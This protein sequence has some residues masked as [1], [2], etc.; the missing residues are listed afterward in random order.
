MSLDYCYCWVLTAD[1]L[2]ILFRWTSYLLFQNLSCYFFLFLSLVAS[3]I[4][5]FS[6]FLCSCFK[7]SM[8]RK[9]YASVTCN[10]LVYFRYSTLKSSI[11]IFSPEKKQKMS[12]YCKLN[13]FQN[14]CHV[15]LKLYIRC[16][17]KQRTQKWKQIYLQFY[18]INLIKG[19]T[20]ILQMLQ[21]K[22]CKVL[23]GGMLNKVES[24]L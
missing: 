9:F 23:L 4:R 5:N 14:M 13:P 6:T 7:T 1:M 11:K 18:E 2:S 12:L 15:P 17:N 24:F 8:L 22:S 3:S 19:A 10:S 16:K 20:Y 21:K